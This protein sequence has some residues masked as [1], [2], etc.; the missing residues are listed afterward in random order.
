MNEVSDDW[1]AI[2]R[3]ETDDQFLGE[4]IDR[5]RELMFRAARAITHNDY[6]ADDVIQRLCVR[7]VTGGIP[8]GRNLPVPGPCAG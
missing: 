7:F 4:L 6:D 3:G 2:G 5:Y 1:R 8:A